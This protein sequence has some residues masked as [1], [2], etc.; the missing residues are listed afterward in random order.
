[1][2]GRMRYYYN[3]IL[4][5]LILVFAVTVQKGYCYEFG[6]MV[7]GVSYHICANSSNP[8][9]KGAPN[10]LDKNGAFVYNPGV[11]F[12]LD[13]RDKTTTPGLSA[14]VI[15]LNFYDCDMRPVYAAGGGLK[16]R[17]FLTKNFSFDGDAYLAVFNAQKWSTGKSR[18]SAMLFPSIGL[19]YHI[20]NHFLVGLRSTFSPKNVNHSATRKFD[21]LF[22]YL[23]F[24][25]NL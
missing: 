18:S 9:Y 19:S 24:A 3:Y 13:F 16:Y 10:R 20:N 1:M 15:A 8:A 25:V 17:Y 21:I 5:L 22:S 11:G 12:S 4:K 6:I 7:T 2:G 23:Y 14:A